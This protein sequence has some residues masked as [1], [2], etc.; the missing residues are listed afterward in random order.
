MLQCFTYEHSE[1]SGVDL[2]ILPTVGY[3]LCTKPH[4]AELAKNLIVL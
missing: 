3:V 4:L 2:P 1:D